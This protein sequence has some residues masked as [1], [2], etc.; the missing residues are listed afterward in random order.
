[1]EQAFARPSHSLAEIPSRLPPIDKKNPCLAIDEMTRTMLYEAAIAI[2]TR[3]H[4]SSNWRLMKSK[5]LMRAASA[6]AS[7]VAVLL[8]KTWIE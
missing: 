4:K 7:A 3:I 8:H 6:V 2:P 5:E 1:M